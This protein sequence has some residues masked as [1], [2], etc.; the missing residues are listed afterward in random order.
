MQATTGK[1][2]KVSYV[3]RLEDGTVFDR[4]AADEPIEFVIGEGKVIPGFDKGVEGMNTGEEK[5][6]SIPPEMGYGQRDE[7]LIRKISR[8]AVPEN[9]KVDKGMVLK[10]HLP[11][12]AA[13]QAT[14]IDITDQDLI[15]DL[16]HTLAGKTLLFDVKLESVE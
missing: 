5:T 13:V 9:L 16:N 3:G 11:N 1:K 7:T 4:S 15:V 8:T 14:V 6:I 10:L 2:V 12:G